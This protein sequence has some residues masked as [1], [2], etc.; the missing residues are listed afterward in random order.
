VI[1]LKNSRAEILTLGLIGALAFSLLLWFATPRGLGLSPDSVAYLKAAQ[2]LLDGHGF[3]Y[4]SVQWPPLFSSTIYIFS[5]L[6]NADFISGARLLNASLYGCTFLLTAALLRCA[7]GRKLNWIVIYFFAAVFCL[8]PVVTTIYFYAFSE[9]LFLPLVLINLLI[10]FSPNASQNKPT[11]KLGIYLSLIGCIATSTRY[12]GLVLIALNSVALWSMAMRSSPPKKLIL[13]VLQIIPT[14]MLLIT[15]RGHIGIGDTE[16]N[17]RPLVWHPVTLENIADGLANVGTWFIPVAHANVSFLIRTSCMAT[18]AIAICVLFVLAA[19][20]TWHR[21]QKNDTES[22]FSVVYVSWI[23]SIFGAG[24]LIF[25]ILMRSFFDPNIVFDPRTLSPIFLPMLVLLVSCYRY[26]A[27]SRLRTIALLLIALIYLFPLQQ[28]RPRLLVSYFN[29]IELNDKSRL[30]SNIIHFLR[31]CPNQ[32][33]VYADRPWSFN[34][35]FKAMVHWLP[36]QHFYGSGLLDPNFQEK[37]RNLPNLAELIVIEDMQSTMET[38]VRQMP[39]FTQIYH[40]HD[41]MIWQNATLPAS[42][43]SSRH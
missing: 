5:L 34:L 17:Q 4:F 11:L 43:C 24:Y 9:A 20:S 3:T 36:T 18:G 16:T 22:I 28:I 12:A 41:G 38:A 21:Y 40:S 19:R 10:L 2:G 42:Y 8:H 33:V 39:N 35:E 23:L 13:V 37:V 14:T 31:R 32:A 26:L 29:G 1:S 15:W 25:L 7:T 30:N 6:L 27:T